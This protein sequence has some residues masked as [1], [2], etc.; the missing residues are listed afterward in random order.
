MELPIRG[1]DADRRMTRISHKPVIQTR[2]GSVVECS[3]VLVVTVNWN[4]QMPFE[5]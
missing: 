2:R 4:R 3:G 5:H 1:G